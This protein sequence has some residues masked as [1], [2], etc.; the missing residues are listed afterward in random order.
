MN[1]RF[2]TRCTLSWFRSEEHITFI[3][4]KPR[5]ASAEVTGNCFHGALQ[6]NELFGQADTVVDEMSEAIYL[7]RFEVD[8]KSFTQLIRVQ[9][10]PDAPCDLTPDLIQQQLAPSQ[11]STVKRGAAER[12]S[13]V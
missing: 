9:Q 4:L 7:R 10:R 11:Y 5:S 3:V 8:A 12:L 2:D 13:T 1:G 6:F